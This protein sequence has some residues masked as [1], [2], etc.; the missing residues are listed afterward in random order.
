MR[1]TDAPFI[2][3]VWACRHSRALRRMPTNGVIITAGRSGPVCVCVC[4]CGGVCLSE[5]PMHSEKSANTSHT[6]AGSHPRQEY[7]QI[8]ILYHPKSLSFFFLVLYH[9]KS[10]SLFFFGLPAFSPNARQHREMSCLHKYASQMSSL[11]SEISIEFH[12][13]YQHLYSIL[14]ASHY[15]SREARRLSPA[16]LI[17][18]DV[19]DSRVPR[20]HK[21]RVQDIL[22]WPGQA[23]WLYLSL[24]A[25]A[26]CHEWAACEVHGRL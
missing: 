4:V 11:L 15:S 10:L 20:P 9:P 2:R 17:R 19:P 6:E 5:S 22:Q 26:A 23:S 1:R 24:P 18:A 13:Y 7:L 25:K 21:Y 3:T 16:P 14:M 12:L 8:M